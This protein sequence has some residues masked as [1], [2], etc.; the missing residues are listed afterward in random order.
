MTGVTIALASLAAFQ[1]PQA[2]I[3][4]QELITATQAFVDSLAAA[5]AFSGVVLLAQDGSTVFQRAWGMADRERRRPNDAETRF[6]LGSINK[7]FTATA[8]R[9][10]AEA[11]RLDLDST[12][13]Q[14]LPDYPNKDVARQVTI[15]Q[16]MDHSAGVGGD[17]FGTQGAARDALRHNRDFVKLF[18]AEPLQFTPGSQ[19]RYSNA[20][21]ILLG[22]VVERVSGLDYYEYVRRNVFIPARMSATDWYPK[23]SLPAN[24]AIGYTRGGPGSPGDEPLHAN[25]ATLP[26]RGSAAGGG[27]STAGDLLRLAQAMKDGRV[28]GA[29]SDR[30][31]VGGGAPGINAA[32]EVGLPGGYTIV[33]LANLDPP[34]A[35]R[36]AGFVREKLGVRSEGQRVVR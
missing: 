9:Q 27:Y 29:P 5:D 26:G 1:T 20:G 24:T 21:Y 23:D 14:Y 3:S 18:A 15:R 33:V 22:L 10:L 30:M 7:L 11:G 32:F 17:I 19:R 6:N 28:R 35:G 8:I 2:P 25:A 12:L 4:R 36:V 16:L 31:G 34:A 13:I